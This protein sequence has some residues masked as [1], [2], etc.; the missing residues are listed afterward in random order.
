MAQLW[1]LL[2]A[3]TGPFF[4]VDVSQ[5]ALVRLTV[6]V[7]GLMIFQVYQHYSDQ[8]EPWKTWP[9]WVNVLFYISL[10]Y[11]IVLFGAPVTNEF[12]YFQF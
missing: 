6:T 1:Y 11:G 8:M 2:N 9:L 12:I 7:V 3:F 10:F 4:A 5:T